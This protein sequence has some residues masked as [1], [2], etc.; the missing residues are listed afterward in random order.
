MVNSRWRALVPLLVIVYLGLSVRAQQLSRTKRFIQSRYS[1]EFEPIFWKRPFDSLGGTEVQNF[2]RSGS[3]VFGPKFEYNYL[4]HRYDADPEEPFDAFSSQDDPTERL[5]KATSQSRRKRILDS[6]GMFQVHGWKRSAAHAPG[7]GIS[8]DQLGS[9]L[10]ARGGGD[11]A[12]LTSSSDMVSSGAARKRALDSLGGFQVHGW[13]KSA[14]LTPSD[15][16]IPLHRARR[17]TGKDGSKPSGKSAEVIPAEESSPEESKE[18][19]QQQTDSQDNSAAMMNEG[20]KFEDPLQKRALD[21][22][23]GFNVHGMKRA[24]DS[25]GGFNVH[26]MKRALDSLGGFNVHGMKR[27]LD[28]LGGFNVHG[29]KRALDSL[30]GFNVHGMK[31]DESDLIDEKRALDSLGG[32]N[33]HGM[34]RALDSLGGFNVHGMKR[35]GSNLDD[36]KRALDSL[37]GFNVHGMKRDDSDLDSEKRALDSLGGFNVHGMKRAID[38]LGGFNVH[39]MKRDGSNLDDEKRALDSLGGFNVHGMKRALDSLGGFNVHGM[40]RTLDY[41][42]GF[43]VHGMKRALD[44]LG[45]FNVHGMKRA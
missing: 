34:K 21:S 22:L 37:G 4:Q 7:L 27:A 11:S 45:G 36:E 28:S 14:P 25:L 9:L 29:M 30:G 8:R 1:G 12:D 33:V 5:Y 38:S 35:D 3:A 18:E 41:L 32:F 10:D 17:S 39:G 31:R 2:K 6:L 24:L 19:V 16:W 23:G 13:K 40:K 43:N 15:G 44:S 42:G 26:G 20:E